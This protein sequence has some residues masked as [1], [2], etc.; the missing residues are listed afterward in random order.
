[1][2]RE[3]RNLLKQVT[4]LVLAA[5]MMFSVTAIAAP[6]SV[7]AAEKSFAKNGGTV[8]I[9]DEESYVAT[10]EYSWIKYKAAQDGYLRVKMSNAT[11]LQEIGYAF[12][13]T[14]LYDASRTKAL[15]TE[16][17]WST[18]AVNAM[19]VTDYYGVKKGKTYYFKVGSMGGVSVQAQL[20]KY[21]DKSGTKK[22]KALNIKKG[23]K[24][25]IGVI[26]AGTTAAHWYKFKLTKNQK[27]N[28]AFTPYSTG[29]VRVDITGPGIR[30]YGGTYGSKYYS[31]ADGKIHQGGWGYKETVSTDGKVRTGT[32]YIKVRPNSRTT[33]GYFKIS[34]K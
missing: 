8:T 25:V 22:Q 17:V 7:K 21:K 11:Q 26:S 10:Q 5:V 15:S 3:K 23:T 9:S 14:Q 30:P 28:V 19:F 31:N 32:Y 13:T 2:K 4:S 12:G 27:L 1:M 6:N 29:P 16:S 24:G 34:W 18:D 20:T 33:T